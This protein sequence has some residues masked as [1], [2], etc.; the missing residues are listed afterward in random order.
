MAKGKWC[1]GLVLL[2]LIS[3]VAANLITPLDQLK[4]HYINS[5][6][7]KN[8][9]V[10]FDIDDTILSNK[11]IIN[12]DNGY[13]LNRVVGYQRLSKLPL[14]SQQKQIYDWCLQNNVKVAFITFRCESERLQ[15]IKNLKQQNI[16]N[17]TKLILFPE[18]CDYQSI[19]AKDYK[20]NE[21]KKLTE[22]GFTVLAAIGDQYSDIHGGYTDLSIKL[23]DPGYYTN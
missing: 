1:C 11:L 7:S 3:T 19:T 2:S 15:T 21:R 10:V 12:A 9:I 6:Q 4:T 18:P 20:T 5:D 16:S 8:L 13:D 23:D 14:I 22:D 17:W